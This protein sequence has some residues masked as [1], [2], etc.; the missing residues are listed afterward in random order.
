MIPGPELLDHEIR[1]NRE[2]ESRDHRIIRQDHLRSR[3]DRSDDGRRVGD[4]IYLSGGRSKSLAYRS[5]YRDE[6]A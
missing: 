2:D 3:A 4:Y 6:K 1:D 5:R